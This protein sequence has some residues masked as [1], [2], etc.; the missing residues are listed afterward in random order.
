MTSSSP[1][2]ARQPPRSRCSSCC[3][4]PP[5]RHPAPPAWP[6]PRPGRPADRAGRG[7]HPRGLPDL[8]HRP[9]RRPAPACPGRC[10]PASARSKATTASRTCPACTPARNYAGAEGPM[11]FEPATFAQYAVNADPGQPL[12]PLRP[13]RRDL[14][15]R[16]D[17]LRQRRP[18]RQP[19]PASSRRSSPTTTPHWYVTEV[20]AWAARYAAP[21]A[22][23]AAA[24][25][26]A[27]AMAPGRQALPVGRRRPGRLRLLRPG[28]RRLRRRGHPHRPHHLPVAAGRPRQSRCPRSSPATC[29]SPP[30]PTAPPPTPAT[31]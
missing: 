2:R 15:R 1:R 10:S 24:T 6:T 11:Q 5:A 28:L 19:A 27:F 20:L 26:I 12:T 21:A 9:P 31:S 14:H 29:C 16:R 22:S 7:R 8:V 3:S 25:A 23:S 18:R 13:G 30:A 4:S 17:A